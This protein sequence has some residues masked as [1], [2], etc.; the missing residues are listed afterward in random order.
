MGMVRQ[1]CFAKEEVQKVFNHRDNSSS[2][3]QSLKLNES[4]CL[5]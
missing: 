1:P 4:H 3:A 5:I 2:R